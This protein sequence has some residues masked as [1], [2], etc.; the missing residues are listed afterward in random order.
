MFGDAHLHYKGLC[1]D[2]IEDASLLCV[3][4]AELSDW[5]RIGSV[6]DERVVR[7]YGIHPWYADQWNADAGE[8]LR[9][10]LDADPKAG[11]GEIGLDYGRGDAVIQ[12]TAFTEQ[13]IIAS[14]YGRFVSVHNVRSEGLIQKILKTDGKG[15]G[16][17]IMHSFSGPIGS[18]QSLVKSGCYFSVSPRLMLKSRANAELILNK[19]PDDRLLIETDA[20]DMPGGFTDMGTFIADIA[21]IKGISAEALA[22][23]TLANLKEAVE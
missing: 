5:D 7:S 17:V 20:P 14:E 19:I 8:R 11:V 6:P 15:C 13:L 1:Y 21:D 10:L 16:S 3:C 23:L 22:E 9:S 2:G 4:S 12:A 18:I